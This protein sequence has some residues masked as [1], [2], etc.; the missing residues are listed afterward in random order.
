MPELHH[1]Q[2]LVVGCSLGLGGFRNERFIVLQDL[3]CDSHGV[4]KQDQ[5]V[6]MRKPDEVPGESN[7]LQKMGKVVI[8]LPIYLL[9][10]E[11]K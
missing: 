4:E 5:L 7:N 11:T 1:N 9:A 3:V 2:N 6:K 10:Y 8:F